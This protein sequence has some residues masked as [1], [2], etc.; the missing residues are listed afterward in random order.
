MKE[1]Q[2]GEAA[3]VG[4]VPKTGAGDSDIPA[5]D[6]PPKPVWPLVA[7]AAAWVVWIAFLLAMMVIRMQTTAV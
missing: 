6:L 7:G 4:D 5:G 3:A 2:A 1:P